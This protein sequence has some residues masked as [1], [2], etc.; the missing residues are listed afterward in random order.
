[1]SHVLSALSSPSSALEITGLR[2]PPARALRKD[3]ARCT[4]YYV[5]WNTARQTS[6]ARKRRVD[7]TSPT[8]GFW[9]RNED[10]CA[11][12]RYQRGA[13]RP[14]ADHT[15]PPV[16]RPAASC[17]SVDRDGE[18]H[19][20]AWRP[21]L[22]AAAPRGLVGSGLREGVALAAEARSVSFTACPRAGREGPACKR[23]S[24]PLGDL[25]LD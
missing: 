4:W 16:G 14:V 3:V 20:P 1:M 15:V 11:G 9:S 10:A 2:W 22:R 19:L 25:S 5:R 12:G 7:V 24:L 21:A 6:V 18:R 17:V 13:C 8:D 23:L